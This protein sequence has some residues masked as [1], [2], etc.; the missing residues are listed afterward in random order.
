MFKKNRI[1]L[2]GALA[3]SLLL[4]IPRLIVMLARRDLVET[5]ELS[6]EE[7]LLRTVVMFCFSW[8]VLSYNIKWKMQWRAR[9]NGRPVLTDIVVNAFLLFT[10]VTVLTF[11]RQFVPHYLFGARSYFFLI[12]FTYFMVQVILLLLSQLVHL[13][14]EQQ[15]NTLEKEQAKREALHH[16]LEALRGQINPHFLFNTLNSLNS[17]IRQNRIKLLFL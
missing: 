9:L 12:L 8:V 1:I 17:L 4:N 10:S 15:Q 2:F 6:F 13:M 16:Q 3:I 14:A 5:F 7:L 11:I